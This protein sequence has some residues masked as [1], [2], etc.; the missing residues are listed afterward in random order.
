MSSTS[1]ALS[2]SKRPS[3][4]RRLGAAVRAH[5]SVVVACATL[6]LAWGGLVATH[7]PAPAALAE[8]TALHAALSDT[9][10]GRMLASVR[11]QRVQL[12]PMDHHYEILGFYRGSTM[13]A[14]VTV[15]YDGKP[16]ILDATDLARQQYAY[17]SNIANNG[18]MLGALS[19]VFIA[20]TAVWPL[21]RIRNLDALVLVGLTLSV[22][23]FNAEMLGRVWLIA[24]PVLLYLAGRCAWWGLGPRSQARASTPLYEHLTRRW[25]EHQRVRVLRWM[26]A[27][28]ALIVAMVG[29][30]SLHI[31]DVGYAAMEGATLLLHGVLPYGHIPDVLHGDT[32]PIGSYLAYMPFAL[33]WPVH[34][35]WDDADATLAVAVVAALLVAAG[36]WRLTERRAGSSASGLRTALALLTFPPLLVTVSTGTTDT[37]LAALVVGALVLW[38]QP[39]SGSGVLSAAAWFKVTPLALLPLWLARLRGATLARAILAAI[40][41]AVAMVAVLI[42]LGGI[43]A[44]LRMLHAMTFQLTRS[45]PQNPWAV[46]GSVPLQ[47]LAEAVTL[48]LLAGAC[49]RIRQDLDLAEDL[50][51]IAAIGAAVMLGTQISA[52]YWTYMYLV[53]VIPL[54]LVSL[55]GERRRSPIELRL[56]GGVRQQRL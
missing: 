16:V 10:A 52:N 50:P 19:L 34:S 8:R 56:G 29:F 39:A 22:V 43:G 38:R 51:R 23:A 14:S 12:I 28:M 3:V 49:V 37:V 11:W 21:R 48:A 46:V 4:L 44:P 36:V 18:W 33:A 9:G 15:G 13:V 17:G 35:V 47:Q 7:R 41:V 24:Y 20:M 27:A 6:A 2:S 5:L 25:P 31:I 45:S 53:W 26:V 54:I 40:L 1:L 32:Y 30:T 55:L 42:G